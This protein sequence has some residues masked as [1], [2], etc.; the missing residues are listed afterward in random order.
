MTLE[1]PSEEDTVVESSDSDSDFAR[2]DLFKQQD[3]DQLGRRKLAS[4]MNSAR[5]GSKGLKQNIFDVNTEGDDKEDSKASSTR[6]T[7]QKSLQKDAQLN[8]LGRFPP[9]KKN[10][11]DQPAWSEFRKET[12]NDDN[13]D[14][15]ATEE[16]E[17]ILEEL[18]CIKQ[19]ISQ[20]ENDISNRIS[21]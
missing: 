14:L 13:R 1:P 9:G 11:N 10:H 21:K 20:I 12:L 7:P 5:K 3:F 18:K 17:R 4:A 16:V 6:K 2:V 19:R 15:V 8:D